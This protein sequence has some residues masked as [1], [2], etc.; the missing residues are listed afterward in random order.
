MLADISLPRCEKK[1]RVWT[2]EQVATF[3]DSPNTLLDLTRHFIGFNISLQ[4]GMRMGEILGLRWSDIDFE[5][6][7]IFVRQTLNKIGQGN[8]YGIVAGGKRYL[9]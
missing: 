7:M 2:A 3:L 6:K 4:T 5:N 8:V 9:P 1:L